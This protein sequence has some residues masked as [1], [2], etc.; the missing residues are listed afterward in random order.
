MVAAFPAAV[1]KAPRVLPGIADRSHAGDPSMSADPTRPSRDQVPLG[2]LTGYFLRLGTI[3]FGGPIALTAAMQRDLVLGRRWITPD[4][5]KEGL[6]LA[7]LAPGPLAAQ[8]AMY[9]GWARYGL[10]GATAAGLAFVGPSLVMVLVLSA[11]YVRFGGLAWMQGVFYGV[12]G[13][14]HRHRGTRRAQAAPEHRRTRPAALDRGAREYRRRG[15]ERGRASV[16]LR[17][18]RRHCAGGA[19]VAGPRGAI[20]PALRGRGA[21]VVARHRSARYRLVG[22]HAAPH[23]GI[24][25][26]GGR[27]RVRRGLAVVPFL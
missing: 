12:G 20:H 17:P 4:E 3:G 11:C 10:A 16:G 1:S 9:L 5:Y 26:Q 8:L 13:R 2:R 15:L 6:A 14:G 7:Q 23:P 27:R 21:L 19:I 22:R 18:Q 24:L 25:R